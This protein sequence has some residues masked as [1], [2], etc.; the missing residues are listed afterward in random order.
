MITLRV[1]NTE[2]TEMG[3]RTFKVSSIGF[4]LKEEE[5]LRSIGTFASNDDRKYLVIDEHKSD[6]ADI[7]LLDADS[8]EAIATFRSRQSR[9]GQVVVILTGKKISER[10]STH[11]MHKPLNGYRIMVTLHSVTIKH[12]KYLP[13]L[14]ISDDAQ[15]DKLTQS[16]FETGLLTH[17]SKG[18]Q[19]V[20]IDDSET[21]RTHMEA[22]LRVFGFDPICAEDGYHGLE[23][24]KETDCCVVFL[25]VNLPDLDGFEVCK[26]I[27][28]NAK[29][30]NV[31]VIMLTGRS[32][33]NSKVKGLMAGC[34]DY[35]TKPVDQDQLKSAL[36]RIQPHVLKEKQSFSRMEAGNA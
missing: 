23:V 2:Q 10:E 9:E 36:L 18:Q 20:V 3:C 21:I 35:L 7:L 31:P 27:K 22:Q 24:V 11:I 13:E 4:S 33:K 29:T 14:K 26:A 19:V 28:N 8:P 32:R 25:D 30:K 15:I 16:A 12:F 34:D 5:L 1:T 6:S 17:P